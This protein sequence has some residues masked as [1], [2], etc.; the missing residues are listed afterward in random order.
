[1]TKYRQLLVAL[2]VGTVV[3][4]IV[5][6]YVFMP[7]PERISTRATRKIVRGMTAAEVEALFG[8][9]PGDYRSPS[10]RLADEDLPA[11]ALAGRKWQGNRC[12]VHVEF[13]DNDRVLRVVTGFPGPMRPSW[14]CALQEW[15]PLPD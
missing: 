14:Y 12:T 7:P 10:A 3:A 6:A 4:T 8:G 13:D 1:V 2:G 9:P 15:L 5:A 11:V